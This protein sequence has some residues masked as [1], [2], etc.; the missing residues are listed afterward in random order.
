MYLIN[1]CSLMEMSNVSTVQKG[2]YLQVDQHIVAIPQ[3]TKSIDEADIEAVCDPSEYGLFHTG[4]VDGFT[5]YYYDWLQPKL[6]TNGVSLPSNF[7][8]PCGEC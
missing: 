7:T 1:G 6:C 4:C 5:Q 2:E 3:V 8:S